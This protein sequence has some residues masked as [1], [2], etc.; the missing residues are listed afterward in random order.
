MDRRGSTLVVVELDVFHGAHVLN[1]YFLLISVR[2]VGRIGRH[3]IW[4]SLHQDF[5]NNFM[6]SNSCRLNSIS[7]EVVGRNLSVGVLERSLNVCL[8]HRVVALLHRYL[9][10]T[11][12]KNFKSLVIVWVV[13]YVEHVS[14]RIAVCKRCFRP[15]MSSRRSLLH[16]LA[17]ERTT[18]Q[19]RTLVERAVLERLFFAAWVIVHSKGFLSDRSIFSFLIL[20]STWLLI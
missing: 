19:K 7:Q 4:G 3:F 17:C 12:C 13:N 2:G 16:C 1:H 6:V 20:S 15:F 10:R 8:V 9:W 14:L 18:C 5:V 11:L